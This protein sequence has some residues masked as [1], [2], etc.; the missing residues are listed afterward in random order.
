MYPPIR[1]KKFHQGVLYFQKPYNLRCT[2][3]LIVSYPQESMG[4]LAQIFVKLAD[5]RQ[6]RVLMSFGT[7]PQSDNKCGK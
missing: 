7:W 1:N 6:F 3:E 2:N 4:F 5:I